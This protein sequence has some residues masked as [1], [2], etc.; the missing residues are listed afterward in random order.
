MANNT[1]SANS[2]RNNYSYIT[3]ANTPRTNNKIISLS[4]SKLGIINSKR[5]KISLDK[6][7]KI[8]ETLTKA[9]EEEHKSTEDI[10]DEPM[11]CLD[12]E[13]HH[14]STEDIKDGPMKCLDI[15]TDTYYNSN[16]FTRN[17]QISNDLIYNANNLQ[18]Q[19]SSASFT[20][21]VIYAYNIY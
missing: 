19:R 2:M 20:N 15:P 18:I 5:K 13:E 16:S 6:C 10:K 4:H 17:K 14:K 8:T 21:K 7:I 11:K 3:T 1:T 9:I 12:I